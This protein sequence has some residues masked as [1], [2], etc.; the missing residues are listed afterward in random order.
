M[1]E[2]STWFI[3]PLSTPRLLWGA[4][5][6]GRQHACP[7]CRVVLLTGETPGFCCGP[8]GSKFLDVPPLPPLPPEYDIFMNDLRISSLSR[9]LNLVFSFASLES[10]HKFPNFDD[11]PAFVAIQGKIYHR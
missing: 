8:N 2:F 7:T 5:R 1:D 4:I 10:T 9:V 11:N 6:A 3:S